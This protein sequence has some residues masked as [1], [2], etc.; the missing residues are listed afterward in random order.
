MSFA[1]S[2][3]AMSFASSSIIPYFFTFGTEK[4]IF[5]TSWRPVLGW[6]ETKTELCKEIFTSNPM[7]R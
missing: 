1:V 5:P 2:D 7:R 3:D 6:I 4:P